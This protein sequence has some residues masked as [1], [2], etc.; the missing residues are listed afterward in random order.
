VTLRQLRTELRDALEAVGISA[1]TGEPGRI[2]PPAALVSPGSPYLEPTAPFGQRL[3]RLRVRLI[4][5]PGETAPTDLD[6]MIEA[7]VP[8]L[9]AAGE[10]GWDVIEIS[11]PYTLVIGTA[12]LPTVEITTTTT[13]DGF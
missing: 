9:E 1:T 5:Q 11:E 8:A 4:A 13:T 12:G 10:A 2:S 7:A 6:D 3:V